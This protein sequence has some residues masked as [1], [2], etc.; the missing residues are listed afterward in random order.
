MGVHCRGCL[1]GFA[2]RFNAPARPPSSSVPSNFA[3]DP[4]KGTR[5]SLQFRIQFSPVFPR[6]RFIRYRDW[7]NRLH[8]LL[9]ARKFYRKFRRNFIFS[10]F[11]IGFIGHS[12][13]F[14]S[15]SLEF[16]NFSNLLH[17]FFIFLKTCL[18][19]ANFSRFR[20]I[21]VEFGQKI[22]Q[23]CAWTSFSRDW[24]R[25]WPA[26]WFFN[27]SPRVDGTRK[28]GNEHVDQMTSSRQRERPP[29]KGVHGGRGGGRGLVAGTIVAVPRGGSSRLNGPSP[30]EAP[31][32][33]FS[34]YNFNSRVDDFASWSERARILAR[35]PFFLFP[36]FLPFPSFSL[37]FFFF[38]FCNQG[39]V[40]LANNCR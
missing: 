1:R 8:A 22:G 5:I 3:D 36:P 23:Q 27:W 11:F 30:W 35:S 14:L 17:F 38:C 33:P 15:N 13:S 20:D 25:G 28:R 34:L 40:A 32:R 21:F 9:R 6:F 29:A 39:T 2:S 7:I 16:E 26:G 31:R 18:H 12:R 37:F 4:E 24:S 10:L 19:F